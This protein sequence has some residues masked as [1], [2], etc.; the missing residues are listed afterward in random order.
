MPK[1]CKRLAE[2]DFPIAEVSKHSAREKSIRHGHPSTLHLWWARRPLAACRAM[3]LGLL[4]PD[5][6]DPL[7]PEQF[8][9]KA[10]A[11]LSSVQGKVGPTDQELRKA[12][13][14][15]IGDFANWDLSANRNY[16]EVSRSLVKAAHGEEPSLVVDPFA[17]GGSIPLEALRL[18]CEAFA[19]D[20][21]PVACLIL[22]VMLE[23]IPRHGPQLAEELRRVGREIKT[24][25]EKELAEFYPK[26][27]DGA[28]PIAY[29]WARTVMCESPNCGAEI[30]L[31]RSFWLCK[32]ANRR[33]A[34]R[35]TVIRSHKGT[36]HVEFEV[37]EPAKESDVPHETVTRARATCLCC[38]SVLPP[39]RVRA[40]LAEQ[41]GGADAVFDAKGRRIGGALM[42]AVVTLQPGI[43]GRNYRLPTERNYH[44]VW[45]AHKELKAILDDW[46]RNGK[47]GLSPVP[48]EPL[49]IRGIR[50]T[51]VMTYGVE[52]WGDL[53]TARQKVALLRLIKGLQ[54][55]EPSVADALIALHIGKG[56]DG[57]SSLS[58]WMAGYENPVNCFSR[59]AIPMVWDFCESTPES[60]SRGVFLS[61]IEDAVHVVETMRVSAPGQIQQGDATESPLPDH[62]A[63]AWFT[64]PPY[65]DAIAYAYLSDFFF[66]WLKRSLAGRGIL[67][68]PNAERNLLS[69]KD[70]EI[71]VDRPH[72]LSNSTKD[73]VSYESGMARAFAEGR[74]VVAADGVGSVVFAHK[75]TEGWE[76][77]LSGIIRGGWTITG[78]WPVATEM[79][80]RLNA[81]DTASLA[82]SVHL[83]CR[84]RP[85]DAP[86]GDWADVLHELPKRVGNWM[87]R[88]Q[89][90]G[91]RGADLVFA[92]IGPALEIF[93]R[94]SRVETADGREVKLAEYLEKVWEVVAR[95]ALRQILGTDSPADFGEDARLTALFLWTLRTT[96]G[97]NGNG[98]DEYIDYDKEEDNA[99]SDEDVDEDIAVTRRAPKGYALPF[100]IVRRIAQ[101]LGIRLDRWN[102]RL[103]EIDKGM[104]RLLPLSRRADF[105]VEPG[106]AH[107]LMLVDSYQRMK[108]TKQ[109]LLFEEPL[110]AERHAEA[111]TARGRVERETWSQLHLDSISTLDH[112]HKAMLLQKQGHTN[113]LRELL[114]YEK[115]YRPEFV[116]LANALSALYPK[117]SEEERLL[118]AMLLA[119]PR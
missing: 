107:D 75:T 105:L 117:G 53:F 12:L 43:Q 30:P 23:D 58:R 5:P 2:V 73:A 9:E 69:P 16:L 51:W 104:V 7:C 81:R 68:D 60:Q 118:D 110:K 94:Y 25:A 93:S 103:L 77:L 39:E 95:T 63:G 27:P 70:P 114:F 106:V 1:E 15:F 48:D 116:R 32:K 108:S 55:R 72:R 97:S 33:R 71:V 10:R 92:C 36:P 96:N 111:E 86:V 101:P 40:Q 45:K 56:A 54:A 8:K 112:V 61:G 14:K 17:G 6:C 41:R 47:K 91:I 52:R 98:N 65:Y 20:L 119:V 84:P 100:D 28:T 42:T 38:G 62:S 13:L 24:Q 78:S 76:A 102:R 82:T 88:L 57:N 18:G 46:E 22:K 90:E 64:D 29:L 66:V 26:D 80:S 21:N 34:L 4:W 59:Q 99:I 50:H 31:V 19:S 37:F 87:E 113:A 67:R 109:L 49:D 85:D 35:Y 11:L 3:L 115:H 89:P 79:G 83:V 74:R 44:A